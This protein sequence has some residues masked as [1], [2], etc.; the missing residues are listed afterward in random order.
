MISII[1][2]YKWSSNTN[3]W[4][5]SNDSAHP[6]E[7][8]FIKLTVIYLIYFI[9]QMLH[10]RLI[11]IQMIKLFYQNR[12]SIRLSFLRLCR[13]FGHHNHLTKRIIPS[14]VIKFSVHRF[15]KLLTEEMYAGE[16]HA[17]DFTKVLFF[18]DQKVT[19]FSS[20]LE[21]DKGITRGN[22]GGTLR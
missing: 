13:F 9:T 22:K 3:F 7:A 18:A 6:A 14:V 10:N 21:P 20:S 19:I 11:K 12:Y 8:T 16:A 1:T 15:N 4:T 2:L 5:L 17:A